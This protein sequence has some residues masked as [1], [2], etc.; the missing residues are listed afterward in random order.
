MTHDA[1]TAE[2][3]ARQRRIEKDRQYKQIYKTARRFGCRFIHIDNIMKV[4]LPNGAVLVKFQELN[5]AVKWS[6]KWK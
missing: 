5:E 4:V 3:D 1:Y 2:Y 6:E